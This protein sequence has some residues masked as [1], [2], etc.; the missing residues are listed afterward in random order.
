[1]TETL[2]DK[3]VDLSAEIRKLNKLFSEMM[4]HMRNNQFFVSEC[5][6]QGQL[7]AITEEISGL[8]YATK[9]FKRGVEELMVGV[10]QLGDLYRGLADSIVA[11]PDQPR[12]VR[13]VLIERIQDQL[14]AARH[15]TGL[16][17][18]PPEAE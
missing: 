5:T 7:N 16:I 4:E 14:A 9:Y 8:I 18:L 3:L 17:A 1:V 15:L 6:A 10:D 2:M 11:M 13:A 12:S